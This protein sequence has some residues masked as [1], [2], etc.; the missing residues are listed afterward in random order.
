M[1]F[2]F[3]TLLIIGKGSLLGSYLARGV[4]FFLTPPCV[5]PS[6]EGNKI[7]I[8]LYKEGWQ[9]QICRGVGISHPALRA[10]LAEGKKR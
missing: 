9:I 7:L 6:H 2:P 10:P 1:N 3:G 4:F 8:P 5:L